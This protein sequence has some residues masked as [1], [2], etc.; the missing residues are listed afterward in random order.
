MKKL[1]RTVAYLLALAMMVCAVDFSGAVQT[2]HA[3]SIDKA[4]AY[5]LGTEQRGMIT[6]NGD[7]KQ[8]Y[9]FTLPTSGAIQLTGSAYMRE[10]Y[11]YLYDSEAN[12]LW[13]MNPSWN[14]TSEV[15]TLNDTTYLTSGTYYLCIGKYGDY[16]G[17]YSF[18]LDFTS[19]GESFR[20]TNG[21]TNN[22]IDVASAITT[23]GSLYS[24]QLA[25]N[26]EKDFYKFN[27]SGSGKVNFSATFY[28]VQYVYWK[29]Y[30]ES[31]EEL[32]SYNPSWNSTTRNIVVDEDLYLTEGTY[33]ISVSRDGSRYGKYS[34]SATYTSSRETY[35]ESGWGVNNTIETAS[36]LSL[37]QNYTGQLAIND[38]KDFYKFSVSSGQ[39]LSVKLECPIEY[40]YVKL[41]DAQGNELWSENPHWNNT[42]RSINFKRI[43]ILEKG[44]YYLSVVRDGYRYG[45]YKLN[46]SKLTQAN[47]P[48]NSFDTTW[49]DAT[50]FARGYR[51]YKCK[52]CGYTY[53]DDYTAVRKLPQGYFYS[54]YCGSGRG[55][56]TLYWSTVSDASGYQIRYCK[57]KNFKSGVVTKTIKGKSNSYK[58]ITKLSRNQKYYVQVRPYKKSGSRTVYGAW[59]S[60]KYMKTR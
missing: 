52:D 56:L 16:Y 19:S 34:F 43:T 25:Y 55:T 29:L 21:G 24:G 17:K 1:K 4:A 15:I 50:Y 60:K 26:D 59:S 12:E 27:L 13:H 6:E 7:E 46:V 35:P 49:H 20:E 57:N 39:T 48:H 36:G 9:K 54:G 53:K 37:G 38:A 51:V 11:L 45:N 44:T 28:D 10:M 47:C 3:Q 2:V 40:V 33:Y 32:L 23:N 5:T 18:K 30:D 31:G 8:Y 22:T 14:S 42:T 58:K 41:Y